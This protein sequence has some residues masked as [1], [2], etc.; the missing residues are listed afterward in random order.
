ML[1]LLARAATRAERER[2]ICRSAIVIADRSVLSPKFSQSRRVVAAEKKKLPAPEKDR[3]K[4]AEATRV[5]CERRNNRG[6]L[7]HALVEPQNVALRLPVQQVAHL[8]DHPLLSLPLLPRTN[9]QIDA[10]PML[11]HRRLTASTRFLSTT[12]LFHPRLMNKSFRSLM[13]HSLSLS[14]P[15]CFALPP[16]RLFFFDLRSR[17]F[18]LQHER[19]TCYSR[20]HFCQ[21]Y[22]RCYRAQ[23]VLRVRYE[24]SIVP[25]FSRFCFFL[26]L[27]AN[28]ISFSCSPFSSPCSSSWRTVATVSVVLSLLVLTRPRSSCCACATQSSHPTFLLPLPLQLLTFSLSFSLCFYTSAPPSACRVVLSQLHVRYFL[29]LPQFSFSFVRSIPHPIR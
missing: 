7:F 24:S 25:F 17:P 19:T 12:I 21:A 22:V 3:S 18:L 10:S 5:N 4:V 16:S 11:D 2:R 27:T 15:S 29:L 23:L 1:N 14:V 28:D 9:R 26:F 8:S 20:A 13:R 6:H